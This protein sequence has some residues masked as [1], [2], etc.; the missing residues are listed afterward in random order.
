MA[1]AL[2]G[3]NAKL[4]YEVGGID[5]ASM[6]ELT[7]V[8]DVTLSLE[9]EEADVTTRSNNGWRATKPTLKNASIEFSMVWDTDDAGFTALRTAFLAGTKI[10][11]K[12]LDKE[13]G[14][15][16]QFD[17]AVMNFTRNEQLAEALTVDVSVKPTYS[18]TAPSWV[19]P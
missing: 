10:G 9:T 4:Y 3:L 1:D 13:S 15:G 2:L 17:A 7:N 14:Q 12:C 6:I 11:M 5:A 16:L 18:T 19:T 8:R